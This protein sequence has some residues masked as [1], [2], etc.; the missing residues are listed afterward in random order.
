[1]TKTYWKLNR[2]RDVCSSTPL[3]RNINKM[4]SADW[5]LEWQPPCTQNPAVA[6]PLT[7]SYWWGGSRIHGAFHTTH[8]HLHR[9]VKASTVTDKRIHVE[10][11]DSRGYAFHR[12]VVPLHHCNA[13]YSRAARFLFPNTNGWISRATQ[14]HIANSLQTE[15]GVKVASKKDGV[16]K[17]SVAESVF[18]WRESAG[19]D[20]GIRGQQR[21]G[22]RSVSVR[23]QETG[24]AFD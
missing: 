23:T 7:Y 19:V 13:T 3:Q 12:S 15:H 1:M 6:E 14:Q 4:A 17:Y 10:I 2:S 9:S 5:K 22:R 11:H 24:N 16:M 18:R 8:P 21:P 20:V